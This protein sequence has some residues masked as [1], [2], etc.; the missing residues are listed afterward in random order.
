[1]SSY[2]ATQYTYQPDNLRLNGTCTLS[3]HITSLYIKLS[4][5]VYLLHHA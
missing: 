1:M 5:S 3:W 4:L 2:P